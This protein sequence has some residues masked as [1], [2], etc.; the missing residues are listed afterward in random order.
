MTALRERR[1][2]IPAR[3]RRQSRQGLPS[4]QGACSRHTVQGKI[5][6]GRRLFSSQ[7][8]DGP[9]HLPHGVGVRH[10]WL[11]IVRLHTSRA[12]LKPAPLFAIKD[13]IVFAV[14]LAIITLRT[15]RV[16]KVHE[17]RTTRRVLSDQGR[18]LS[19][20]RALGN[21]IEAG[22]LRRNGS[23]SRKGHRLWLSG[24]GVNDRQVS[25]GSLSGF[26][27]EFHNVTNNSQ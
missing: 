10:V 3:P 2:H 16:V 11:S 4:L 24:G 15:R 27:V 20:V 26:D 13:P 6:G 5:T 22:A 25:L 9:H 14:A 21:K 23:R 12:P 18:L 17:S 19:G 7:P 8:P 1:V